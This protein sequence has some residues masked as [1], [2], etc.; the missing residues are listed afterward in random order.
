MLSVKVVVGAKGKIADTIS[1]CIS[2]TYV[3]A[4][5]ADVEGHWL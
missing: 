1:D 5:E 2:G 3:A 4:A